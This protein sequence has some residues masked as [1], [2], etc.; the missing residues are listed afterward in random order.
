M[1]SDQN[2]RKPGILTGDFANQIMRLC[3]F[4]LSLE[5]PL[6]ECEQQLAFLDVVSFFEKHSRQLAG[7]LGL[8]R[9]IR[10]SFH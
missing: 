7:D 9:N 4:Q 1:G 3:F 6:V 8:D 10:I 5:R 2:Q